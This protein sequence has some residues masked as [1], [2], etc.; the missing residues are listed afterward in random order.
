MKRLP[1]TLLAIGLVAAVGT[2]SAQSS[3]Y[4]GSDPYRNNNYAT[5]QTSSNQVHAE[6]RKS[7]V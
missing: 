5:L 3:G 1:A 4:Y 6:D 7:V 2:A